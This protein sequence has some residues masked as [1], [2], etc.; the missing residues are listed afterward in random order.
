MENGKFPGIDG[1]PIEFYKE[2]IDI[3][4]KDLQKIFNEILF[5]NKKTP[6]TW[7][8]AIITLIPKKGDIDYLKYWR[9]ISLLCVDYK[10][11]TNI[12]ANRLKYILPDIISTEQNCSIPNRTIFD[13]I[14]LIRD[15]ISY[16]KQKNNHFYL[17]Q[18][19]QQKAFDKIDR[20]F[21]YKTM[22]KMGFPPLFINFLETLYKQNISMITNNGFLSPKVSLQRGLRQ[23]CPLYLPLYVIQSQIITTNIKQDKTITGIKIPHQKEQV[24]ISQYADDSNYFLKSQESV[25][26]VLTFFQ[27]LNE[28]TGA[29]IN[30]EKTTVLPINTDNTKQIQEI[31]PPITVKEQFETTKILGIYFSED[32]KN[33]SHA[34][35]DNVIEKMEKHINILSP[36][37]LSLYGKTIIINTLILSKTSHLSNVFPINSDKTNKIN[38]KIFNYLWSN[39]TAEPIA[40][41]TT[42]LKQK[43]GGLNLLEP[44]AHNYALRIKHLMTLN[45]KGNP[46]ALE[47]FCNLLGD[48]RHTQLY[49]TI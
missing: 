46:P 27:N 22:E 34:N 33:A 31:T 44:E 37:T 9:P 19:D 13:N 28:A 3:I 47:K 25:K 42:H 30:L 8:Q 41:K 43:L 14:F 26:K 10:I 15:I 18:I 21:P 2:F 4:K 29:T 1:I 49:K 32:L 16:T 39:K 45:Q 38:K 36:R 40:R 7:N 11:L 6:K 12:L 48:I 20:T 23:G 17:L 5:T 24:K 35:W